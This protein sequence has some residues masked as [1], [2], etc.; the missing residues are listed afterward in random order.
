MTAIRGLPSLAVLMFLWTG[1]CATMPG[2]IH[3]DQVG[4]DARTAK[5]ATVTNS[6]AAHFTVRSVS[7]GAVVFTD[8]LGPPVAVSDAQEIVRIADFSALSAPGTY[9][10][11]IGSASSPPFAIGET[12]HARV[13][14]QALRSYYGQ[15]CGTAVDLAPDDP[16]YAHGACHLT[17]VYH[18]SSGRRGVRAATGGWHDAGDYGRYVVNSGISTGTLLWAWELFPDVF[19][20][21]DLNIPESDNE[22]PDLLDEVR[23]NLSWMLSMQDVDGGVWHKLTSEQFAPMVMPET[24]SL[25]GQ[26]I[27]TAAPP[28][29]SSCATADFAAVMA[30]AA[31]VYEPFD[32]AFALQTRRAA[33]GAWRWLSDNPGVLFRN[34]PAVST[35]EYDDVDC[36]DERLWAAA[37]LWRTTG[38]AAIGEWF[39][40]H[41]DA[42]LA[43]IGAGDPPDWQGVGALGAWSYA[44]SGHGELRT[45]D[46]I[47]S[48]SIDAAQAIVQRAREHG[49][50]VPLQT[51][52]Y[53]WGS[54]AVAA[55]YG[56]QLLVANELQPDPRYREAAADIV[57]YLLGRNPLSICW[58]TGNGSRSMRR[59]HHRPSI[60]DG[61]DAPWPGLLAGGPN[62]NR[63]DPAMAALPAGTPPARM[64]LDVEESFATNEVAI[65][66][67]APLVFLLAGVQQCVSSI[68]VLP[69][70]RAPACAPPRAASPARPAARPMTRTPRRERGPSAPRVDA[71]R[72]PPP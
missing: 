67:N 50:R 69:I 15:R 9:L 16:A 47:R 11:R 48:R 32:A 23:W 54:N 19:R 71:V 42:V 52:D 2:A 39:V 53:V 7:N 43:S 5:L 40:A 22:T 61:N 26:V 56:L 57:H 64:Y 4:Y 28:F 70:A 36:S 72:T 41:T 58:L 34:P 18:P 3:V 20:E 6:S 60:A 45:V 17:E 68:T 12:P 31:R 27:G 59:P 8:R 46:A 33:I 51:D 21:L 35:G 10:V 13:L 49:Y 62:R 38:D 29:K 30:V 24:D 14:R 37:E 1:A 55:N 66:W 44:L 25:V 63:Q 65:N